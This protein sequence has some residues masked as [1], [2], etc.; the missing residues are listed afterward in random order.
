MGRSGGFRLRTDGQAA[1]FKESEDSRVGS[2]LL[3]GLKDMVGLGG[4]RKSDS[5]LDLSDVSFGSWILVKVL[6]CGKL[7]V[8]VCLGSINMNVIDTQQPK[9][10]CLTYIMSPVGRSNLIKRDSPVQTPPTTCD[11]GTLECG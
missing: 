1:V 10:M 9:N 4:A 6:K 8:R 3:L 11:Y 5:G 7:C 2:F